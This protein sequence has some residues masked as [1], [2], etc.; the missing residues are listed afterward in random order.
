MAALWFKIFLLVSLLLIMTFSYGMT[1]GTQ[2][3][4]Q[5]PAKY[6]VEQG[7]M[8]QM[9]SSRKLLQVNSD[10]DDPH[11]NRRHRPNPMGLAPSAPSSG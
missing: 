10:Y 1:D 11:A 5:M 4:M 3:G 9:I 2:D 7:G 8:I 6:S